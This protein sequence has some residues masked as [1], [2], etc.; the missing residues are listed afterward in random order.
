MARL[1][2]KTVFELYS[3]PKIHDTLSE[4]IICRIPYFIRIQGLL[5]AVV[6]TLSNFFMD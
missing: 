6:I 1:M 5:P 3:F 4:A 2:A